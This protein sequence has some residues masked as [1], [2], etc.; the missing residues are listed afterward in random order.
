MCRHSAKV[1][2]LD[3]QIYRI[4]NIKCFLAGCVSFSLFLVGIFPACLGSAHFDQQ[5]VIM[6]R[7]NVLN[8]ILQCC[9]CIITDI[10]VRIL[11]IIVFLEIRVAG[12]L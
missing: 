5:R 11:L 1:L 3:L 2:K 8:L 10:P 7:S 12:D 6:S 4:T 9:R